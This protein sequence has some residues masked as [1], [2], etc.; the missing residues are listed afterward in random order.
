TGF[1][2]FFDCDDDFEV[3][4]QLLRVA[5]IE[6]KR[7][8]MERMR[9]PMNFST[10]HECGFL[11][12]GF[13]SPPAVMMTYNR[14]Y[15][16]RLAEKFGLKKA[17]DLIAYKLSKETPVSDRVQHV[18]DRL[19]H[20]SN[21]TLRSL[22]MN[23]FNREVQL[24][25]EVYNQAWEHNWGFVPISEDEFRYISRNLRQIIDPEFVFLAEHEGRPIAFLMALPDVNQALIRLNGRLFPLGL[26]KLLWHTKI[27]NKI[28]SLRVVTMGV[29]P[30]FRRRGVEMMLYTECHRRIL[31]SG[32]RWAELS[33]VL[34]TNE[35]MRNT[36][37]QMGAEPYK[38][39]RIVEMP[40]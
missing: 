23:D 21:V 19:R 31:R 26:F 35:L 24:V 27:R 28:D 7:D 20:R 37:T 39:Y 18:I 5:M 25:R 22:N 12:E 32:Y 4:R 2:G 40:I 17:M 1:F 36:M 15:L 9:G 30:Q 16:P 6:L 11:I 10:N 29:V 38:K 3:A 14:P 13:D 8:G 33:W 34:E